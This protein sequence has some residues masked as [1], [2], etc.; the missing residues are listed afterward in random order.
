MTRRKALAAVAVAAAWGLT[1]GSA[2]GQEIPLGHLVDFSGATSGVGVPYGSGIADTFDYINSQG[3]IHGRPLAVDRVDYGYQAPRA[4]SQYQRWISRGRAVAIEGWGTADTEALVTFIARD[5]VPYVSASYSAVL[6]DP[7]GKGP[8]SDHG[9][10]YNFFYGP[11]YSDA[12]RGLLEW[13]KADWDAKGGSGKPGFVHMGAN[14]P[15][16]NAPL[17]AGQELAEA[18]GFEVVP[19]IRYALTPGDYTSQCLTLKNS[20]ADYAYLANTAGSTIS[21]LRACETVGVE[22]QFMTNVWGTDA[23]SMK[24]AGTAADGIVFPVRT[25]AVWGQD[26]P[27]MATVREISKMSDPTG[28]A[29]RSVHYLA[30][31]C[32]AYLMADPIG[33]AVAAGGRVTGETIRDGYYAPDPW[34]PGGL[35]GVCLPV[36]FT[37][38][39]HRGMMDVNI[40]RGRVTGPTDQGSVNDLIA[41]GTISLTKLTTIT[42]DRRDEWLGW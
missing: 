26:L 24:A 7:Q 14:H 11:S 38:E 39:D 29:Y 15:F 41:D 33:R 34:V 9:A 16:P 2:V 18:L 36:I 40:Y 5:H 28:E 23:V 3:G 13:A 42:L 10:P 37:P 27:A 22:V 1:A 4:I 35:D 17:A 8:R 31:V 12:L 19:T 30:G 32:A 25:G 21:L 20:G 6:T